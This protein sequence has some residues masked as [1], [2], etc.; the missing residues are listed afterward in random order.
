MNISETAL[1][2]IRREEGLVLM[3]YRCPAGRLTIG[4]GH[5]GPDVVWGK[6]ITK[7]EAERLFR[8]DVSRFE[9][10]VTQL[11]NGCPTTQ[12][13][14]DALVV[15]AYNIGTDID[16]DTIPEGLGDS[17]LLKLHKAGQYKD[18]ADQFLKWDKGQV[19]GVLKRLPG[20]TKRRAAERAL[21]LK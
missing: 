10:E 9:R 20:L 16:A 14:F 13:Q 21:Y 2:M 6:T 8:Q 3:T 7:E 19:K 11:L 1:D 17:T 5:T 18:A 15:L 4:Y 12:N